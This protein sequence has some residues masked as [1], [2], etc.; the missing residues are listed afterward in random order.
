M[1]IPIEPV[2]LT[3]TIW[4][5]RAA[6]LRDECLAMVPLFFMEQELI[7]GQMVP[8]LPSIPL[9]GNSLMAYYRKSQFVPMK[10]RI[11]VNQLCR[12][13][14]SSPPWENRILAALPELAGALGQD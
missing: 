7:S 10:V 1:P 3:N 14:G 5:L 4:L 13:Y 9:Q 2:Y 8:V 11:F 6:I 12:K